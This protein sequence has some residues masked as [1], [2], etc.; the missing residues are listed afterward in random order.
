MASVF[1][2]YDRDDTDRARQFARALEKAGHEVWWDLHVRGGAQFSKVI[3]EALT[4]A[5]VIVVLWSVNA[6][7]SPWV[8][9]EAAAGRD[10]NR[11]VP[12][13]IDGTLPPL[14]FRQFQT[15]DLSG[16]KGRGSPAARRTFLADVDATAGST[17]AGKRTPVSKTRLE[18]PWLAIGT[19]AALLILMGT[20]FW[21]WRASFG[22]DAQVVAVAAADP[23]SRELAEAMLVN[24]AA[25]PSADSGSV[26]LVGSDASGKKSDLIFRAAA[27]KDASGTLSLLDGDDG[28]ILWSKQF[29]SSSANL[30]QRQSF[31]AGKVLDCAVEALTGA[32]LNE[33]LLKVYLSAC[34]NLAEI[35]WNKTSVIDAMRQVTTGA[36]KFSGAWAKLLAAEAGSEEAVD[37]SEAG[38]AFR[39]QIAS[40][41]KAARKA[42]DQLAEAS[43]AEAVMRPMPPIAPV[44]ELIDKA[45]AQNPASE[46]ILTQRAGFMQMVGRFRE[47]LEDAKRVTELDPMSA[48]ARS[49]YILILAYAGQLDAARRKLAEA[50]RI[51]PEANT[52]IETEQSIEMRFGDFERAIRSGA[53]GRGPGAEDYV[54]MRRNPS[55]EAVERFYARAKRIEMRPDQ[56]GFGLQAFS[57][58]GRADTGYELLDR[59]GWSK[60]PTQGAYILFRPTMASFRAN[61]R[62][63]AF[64][65]SLG[66]VDY[67]QISGLWPDFCEDPRLPYDCRKEAAKLT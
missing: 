44:I 26:T 4:A 33:Q 51:W 41:I 28:S 63:M 8:R 17:S 52:I 37:R 24:L 61:P 34:A 9:D 46:A 32:N 25:L 35:G 53:V 6:I 30:A 48:E 14:G 18:L 39:M 3:E 11:L 27:S 5:D 21:F 7:E 59:V 16:W 36:P 66:L 50:K 54:A 56:L 64:A 47:A 49:N 19:V 29:E 60:F 12:V 65:K 62:F 20:G 67:W 45:K 23:G 22:R 55:N 58:V 1:L 40:D 43:M 10:S 31:A 57:E 15:I 13:T 42:D 2:S 38:R